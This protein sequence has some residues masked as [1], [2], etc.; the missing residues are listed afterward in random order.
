MIIT[1]LC[2]RELTKLLFWLQ[3][4]YNW[5]LGCL[6]HIYRYMLLNIQLRNSQLVCKL[7]I[8][9]NLPS[10]ENIS[11]HVF[12][13]VIHVMAHNKDYSPNKLP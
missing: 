7:E 5:I 9:N 12:G 4:S 1:L 3:I 2:F 10:H 11:Q 13:F 6:N 8:K